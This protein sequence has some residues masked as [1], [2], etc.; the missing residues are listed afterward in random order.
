MT[1]KPPQVVM[2]QVDSVEYLSTLWDS[3]VLKDVVRR[4]KV[5]NVAGLNDIYGLLLNAVSSKFNYDSLGRAQ[6]N[7]ISAPTIKKFMQYAREAYLLVE[8]E[9][10]HFSPRKR[11]KSD[12]KLYSYDNGFIC[13]KRVAISQDHGRL[14]ENLVFGELL[15][16]GARPNVDLFYY[17]TS[18]GHEV[19]F[20]IRSTGV[21]QELIQVAWVMSEQKTRERELRALRTAAR[22]LN[23]S[24]VRILTHNHSEV[25]EDDG[26]TINIQPVRE[27]MLSSK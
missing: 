4:H 9:Q 13:A 16:R 6:G 25:I 11:M 10:F 1:Y 2:K 14:L 12:R 24:H 22:E 23:L 5:R 20:I 18:A 15:R 19:D 17:V 8:L 3:V 26:I 27:W 7:G 21:T